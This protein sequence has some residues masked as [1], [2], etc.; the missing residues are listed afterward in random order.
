MKT[1]YI[2]DLDATLL[3][4]KARL[5]D[6][7]RK[8]LEA[9]MEKGV[10]FTYAS[11]RSYVSASSVLDGFEPNVPSIIYNGTFIRDNRS[12][13]FTLVDKFRHG[14]GKEIL[15]KLRE[16]G[17]FPLV[18]SFID[19]KEC[20][21]FVEEELSGGV[22]EFVNEHRDDP[23]INPTSA[24]KL[25]EG[26]I[27]HFTCIDSE[28]KLIPMYEALK[29]EHQCVYYKEQYSGKWWLE[30]HPIGA[31][32]ANA[33]LK[34]KEMLGAHKIVCFGDGVN[35]ISM[36]EVSDECYAPSNAHESVKAIADAV[37][38]SNENDGVVKWLLENTEEI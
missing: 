4:N 6:F 18:Y 1:L 23:R 7:T 15:F 29:N 19:S 21:S 36:F 26:E 12:G 28:E 32:K 9:L 37:I 13:E 33:V 25:D 11:A 20:F 31:T 5:S 16:N 24:D 22:L 10:L 14:E 2:S 8:T 17:I 38:D 34:L 3:N 30:I 27:F 35:D